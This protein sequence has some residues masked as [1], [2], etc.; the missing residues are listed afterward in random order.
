M[1]FDEQTTKEQLFSRTRQRKH[2]LVKRQV[3]VAVLALACGLLFGL[4]V[5]EPLEFLFLDHWLSRAQWKTQTNVVL[6]PITKKS[7]QLIGKW[8]WSPSR[9]SAILELLSAWNAR[10]IYIDRNFSEKWPEE[11]KKLFSTA[12]SKCK[13]PVFLA[14]DFLPRPDNFNANDAN[15]DQSGSSKM[16]WVGPPS[17]IAKHAFFGH[18]ELTLGHDNVFRFWQPWMKD[19][20]G[21]VYSL[22]ALT[23]LM[24]LRFNFRDRA[25]IRSTKKEQRLIPWNRVRFET[26]PRVEFSDLMQ[27]YVPAREGLPSLLST[28]LFNNKVVFIGLADEE[29][30]ASGRTPWRETVFPFEAMAAIFDGLGRSAG[31]INVMAPFWQ[32]APLFILVAGLLIVWAGIRAGGWFWAG[33][34]G[35]F[36]LVTLVWS[37][38]AFFQIWFPFAAIFLFLLFAG[39]A[40]FTFESIYAAGERSVLFQLATRDGLTNLYS[41]RHFRLIMNQIA[42]EAA[43]RKESLAVIL[44]DIDYFKK[45]NDSYGHAAGDMVIKKTAE[46]IESCVRQKR[47]FKDVDFVARYGGEEF[48]VLLRRSSL[49]NAASL[50]AERIRNA[51]GQTHFEWRLKRVF[52]TVSLGVGILHEGENVPDPMVHRADKALYR[53]KEAGRNCV[54][55]EE[56]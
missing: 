40:L 38:F 44:I 8:P 39:G 4:K 35:L 15:P 50:V 19:S 56:V 6:V 33:W 5:F 52:V 9:Y 29:N 55:I 23:M 16:E 11:E 18:H 12:L 43:M 45:I 10:A 2:L 14:A 24:D 36:A 48:I 32:S 31:T 49:E 17:E 30:I 34:T 46:V 13:V 37:G 7:I 28:T 41:I 3:V 53:A 25:L 42:L 27:N 51:I 21:H 1:N 54:C 47:A 26:W 22:S 20:S